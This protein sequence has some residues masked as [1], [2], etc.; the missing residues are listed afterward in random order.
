MR[1]K[2]DIIGEDSKLL[3]VRLGSL[4]HQPEKEIHENYHFLRVCLLLQYAATQ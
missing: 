2:T 3:D 4:S 1:L